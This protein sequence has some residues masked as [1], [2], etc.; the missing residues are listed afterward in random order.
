LSKYAVPPQLEDVGGFTAVGVDIGAS[1]AVGVALGVDATG[2]DGGLGA[3]PV[4]SSKKSKQRQSA[5][6]LDRVGE[7]DGK[8][9]Q[10]Q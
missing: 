5:K 2:D 1:I 8:E 3:G 10:Q 9:Q 7:L 6:K 4:S